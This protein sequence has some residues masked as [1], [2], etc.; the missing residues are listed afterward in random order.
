MGDTKIEWA[1]KSWNPVVGCSKISPA[2]DNCYAERMAKR[3]AGRYGYPA[4]EPFR[5]TLHP[6]RLTEPL[7]WKKPRRIFVVSM[8]DLF[9]KDVPFDYVLRIWI[10]MAQ[11][12]RHTFMILTKRPERMAR[13]I[14][15]WLPGAFTLATGVIFS[16]PLPNVWL[17][18]TAEDQQR[19][20]E[21][22]PLLL[23]CPAAVRFVSCEPLLGQIDFIRPTPIGG[24]TWDYLTGEFQNSV[25]KK[26]TEKIDWVIAGSESGPGT[27]PFRPELVP[28]VC[29][30]SMAN[31]ESAVLPKIDGQTIR[32]PARRPRMERIPRRRKMKPSEIKVGKT[33]CN[34]GKGTSLSWDGLL[35]K[36]LNKKR[37]SKMIK[38]PVCFSKY[39]NEE[40]GVISDS[41]AHIVLDNVLPDYAEQ[42][43]A[44]LNRG[45]AEPQP[46][47]LF[48]EKVSQMGTEVESLGEW[49][50][51]L[52][53][54]DE[55]L[56][57][58]G[59]ETPL[60]RVDSIHHF[61]DKIEVML[62]VRQWGEKKS[63]AKEMEAND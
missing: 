28:A 12:Q 8:G 1:E 61:H 57:L 62:V 7:R 6:E 39:D 53:R 35:K 46:I 41:R 34:A 4:D 37:G 49:A 38:L 47:K 55:Y 21:R 42:I 15:D 19:A 29:A 50:G 26:R 32:P 18:V 54:L 16:Q 52:P 17:G 43:V 2:C 25:E 56:Y 20:D 63:E 58:P 13:F 60:Y 40:C 48:C 5:V 27:V 23:Q 9:H 14:N 3:L 59:D 36:L 44:A 51:V 10:V 22:I 11:S 24:G 33:Y 30:R 45:E 31:G